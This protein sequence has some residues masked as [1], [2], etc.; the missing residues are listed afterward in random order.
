MITAY[1]AKLPRW[2]GIV[3]LTIAL[4]LPAIAAQAGETIEKG[5]NV[6]YNVKSEW[7]EVSEGH[8][9]GFYENTGLGFH[10]DGEMPVIVNKGTFDSI[11]G[12]STSRG[13]LTKTFANGSTYSVRYQGTSKP[14]GDHKTYEGAYEYVSGTGRYV[15][16]Q[17][18]GTY[19]GKGY[20]K[21][22]VIDYEG[23]NIVPE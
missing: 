17:G 11:K 15:G 22:S 14:E 23:K 7:I 18:G 16:I 6:Q 12:I 8:V 3:V 5:R 2:G 13:Y 1:L 20:G 10:E 21:M 4:G 19:W 9:V